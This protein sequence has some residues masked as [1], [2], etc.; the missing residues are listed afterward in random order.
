M[1]LEA[2]LKLEKKTKDSV[3]KSKTGNSNI[4]NTATDGTKSLKAL[5]HCLTGLKLG[6]IQRQRQYAGRWQ[7]LSSGLTWRLSLRI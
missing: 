3:K 2:Y 5:I 4:T 7:R 1:S 6:K